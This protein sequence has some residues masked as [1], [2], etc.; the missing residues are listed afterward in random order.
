MTVLL[1]LFLLFSCHF[2]INPA[3]FILFSR[4]V[5]GLFYQGFVTVSYS[6]V[7]SFIFHLY[8]LSDACFRDVFIPHIF[9][10]VTFS[11][12]FKVQPCHLL[13][14]SVFQLLCHFDLLKKEQ[15]QRMCNVFIPLLFNK[16]TA[17][18]LIQN[19]CETMRSWNMTFLFFW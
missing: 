12:M 2:S 4:S 16:P 3:L 17:N 6:R 7:M 13:C 8:T 5:H 15:K 1:L 10:Q 19:K 14:V 9:K 18:A 11:L